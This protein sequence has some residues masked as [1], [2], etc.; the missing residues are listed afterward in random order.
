LH[1]PQ[2]ALVR[3]HR[4]KRPGEGEGLGWLDAVH[5]EDRVL[6]EEAFMSRPMPNGAI[7]ASISGCAAPTASTAGRST[8]PPP[9]STMDGEY[10]G[11]V[12]SVMDIDERRET[13]ARLA[14]SEEQLR[15]ATE[16][17]EIGLWDVDVLTDTMFW[18]PRVKAMF[19][20]SPEVPVTLA[21]FYDGRAS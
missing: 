11:Y 14:L 3:V 4:P 21:D 7:T 8:P 19:G 17:A 18:P 12:G 20:I 10:L 16:S 15:L 1:L 6:A 13:E 9:A 5:P 2:S